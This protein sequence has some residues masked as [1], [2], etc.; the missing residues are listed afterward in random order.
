MREH[1]SVSDEADDLVESFAS[2]YMGDLDDPSSFAGLTDA[3]RAVTL[4][5]VMR[6]RVAIDGFE[7]WVEA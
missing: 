3:E 2:M 1:D 7:G 5:W 6:W 4:A